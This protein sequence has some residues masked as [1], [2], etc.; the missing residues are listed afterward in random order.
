MPVTTATFL[1]DIVIFIR[2]YLRSN[3]TDPLSRGAGGNTFVMTSYPKRSVQYPIIT[4]RATGI[5][6]T[7]LGLQSEATWTNVTIEIRTW[8]RNSKESDDLTQD[9]IISLK[10]AQFGTGGT[11]EEGIYDFKLQSTV[12]VVEGE[13]E[14][15][16]VHSKIM[17][18]SYKTILT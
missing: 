10:N 7:R 5:D 6:T 18:Y 13:G 9:V 2:N 3:I 15:N 11:V 14:Q 8:A 16:L 1:Q 12:P 4:V 17:T